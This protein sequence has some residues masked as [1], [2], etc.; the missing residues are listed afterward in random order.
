MSSSSFN[1]LFIADTAL[2][3]TDHRSPATFELFPRAPNTLF[4]C[5]RYIAISTVAHG[6]E[7]T[8]VAEWAMQRALSMLETHTRGFSVD[9]ELLLRLYHLADLWKEDADI[10]KNLLQR[11]R[12]IWYD[13]M[14]TCIIPPSED[15]YSDLVPRDCGGD[16]IS[17]LQAALTLKESRVEAHALFYI[18]ARGDTYIQQN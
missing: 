6:Y 12:K 13:A 7:A 5:R 1:C 17:V 15:A 14:Y 8:N 2:L 18:L 10:E 4:K 3:T 16:P 9:T 11:A